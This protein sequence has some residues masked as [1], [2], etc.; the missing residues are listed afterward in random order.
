MDAQSYM[1]F[2]SIF[3]PLSNKYKEE[4]LEKARSLVGS[5]VIIYNKESHNIALLGGFVTEKDYMRYFT[6]D[7]YSFTAETW[8]YLESGYMAIL[9]CR[10]LM[11][12][13]TAADSSK[14][15]SEAILWTYKKGKYHVASS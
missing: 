15:Y 8:L 3:A 4:E 9:E 10:L 5:K 14:Y 12:Q 2:P 6:Q 1:E 11:I 13:Q 7:Y